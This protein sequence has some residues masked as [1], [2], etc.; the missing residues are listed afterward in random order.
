M[1]VEAETAHEATCTMTGM[2][3]KNS[4]VCVCV[5]VCICVCVCVCARA[6]VFV[7]MHTC[8]RACVRACVS[9]CLYI[10]QA[11]RYYLKYSVFE[12]SCCSFEH[13]T[14]SF[15]PRCCD[16]ISCITI[17][18]AIS[19]G[20]YLVTRIPYILHSA[21]RLPRYMEMLVNAPICHG[22]KSVVLRVVLK[23]RHLATYESRAYTFYKNN[24]RLVI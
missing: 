19:I 9:A 2:F 23:A 24:L 11:S 8:V 22:V 15:A 21:W 7:C 4:C 10:Y 16:S 13:W 5:C 12:F 18:I 1:V 3:A 6:R 20:W 17:Y 14:R